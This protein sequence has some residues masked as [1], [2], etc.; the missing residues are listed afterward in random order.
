MTMHNTKSTLCFP[1]N[2]KSC[3][4][5]CPPIRPAGYEHIQ[6]KNM[7]K[8]ILRE[9]TSE[10]YKKD[11]GIFPI[12]GFS[13]WALGYLDRDC[14][15]V[16]CLLHPAQNEGVDLRFQV[17]YGK[18][19]Q[20][21]ICPEAKVFLELGIREREFWLHLSDDLD[22]FSYSSRKLNPL[23]KMMGWGAD[24]LNLAALHENGRVMKRE[25]FFRSYPIFFNQESPR[26]NAYLLRQLVTDENVHVLK[27]ESFCAGFEKFSARLTDKLKGVLPTGNEAPYTHLLGFDNQF[28]DYLRLS[29]GISKIN[30][31]EGFRL[32]DFVDSALLEFKVQ[33]SMS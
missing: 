3:F 20:R 15:L 24:L 23:F 32:K 25:S 1:G 8:R 21:E 14:R 30:R 27:T 33:Y 22:S 29:V 31:E 19:C 13:C 26:A 17:D 28:L 7:V 18:K 2:G 4:A 6:Y 10:Y 9:N 12:T 11:K 5:C 16:G